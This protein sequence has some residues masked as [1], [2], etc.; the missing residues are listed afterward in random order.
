MKRRMRALAR[1]ILPNRGLPG[2]DHV[3]IGRPG[4]IEREFALLRTDLEGALDKVRGG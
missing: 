3:M 2:C 4:G 1:E